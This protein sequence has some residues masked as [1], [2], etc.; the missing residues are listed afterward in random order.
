MKVK[1]TKRVVFHKIADVTIDVPDNISKSEMDE[2][3]LMNEN[4][5]IFKV[6]RKLG[7]MN[8]E[9]NEVQEVNGVKFGFGLGDGMVDE[10][11]EVEE[12]YDILD[13]NGKPIY[14]GHI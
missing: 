7:F 3:L 9:V 6:D 10:D 8:D 2:W 12:R 14:G 11:A 1:V 4:E 13:E 5:W